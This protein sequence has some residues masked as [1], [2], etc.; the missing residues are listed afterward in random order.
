VGKANVK[1]SR[2]IR[3][4]RKVKAVVD[5][6]A[7]SAGEGQVCGRPI[8]PGVTACGWWKKSRGEGHLNSLRGV[9]SREDGGWLI[10]SEDSV[11]FKGKKEKKKRQL[12]QTLRGIRR[13][14]AG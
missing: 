5:G 14:K 11:R 4:T 8:Y 1:T 2:K 13:K 9:I 7:G 3:K 10:D 6:D 12:H